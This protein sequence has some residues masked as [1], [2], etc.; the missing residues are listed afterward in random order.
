M[1]ILDRDANHNADTYIA[2]SFNNLVSSYRQRA[3]GPLRLS[4]SLPRNEQQTTG[5]QFMLSI[6]KP[7]A[8]RA[9]GS[10]MV[11]VS[12]VNLHTL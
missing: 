5:P 1:I 3:D 9:K 6:S 8:A 10:N 12:E 4:V 7:S 2:K 11:A